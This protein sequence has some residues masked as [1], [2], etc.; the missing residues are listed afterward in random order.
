M[1]RD[2]MDQRINAAIERLIQA[3]VSDNMYHGGLL[4]R[5]TIRACDEL[6]LL[7]STIRGEERKEELTDQNR[8]TVVSD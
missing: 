5:E 2:D 1:A 8:I 3:I 6:Q 7:R 4:S